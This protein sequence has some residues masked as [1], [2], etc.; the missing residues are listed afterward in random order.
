MA[1]P[2]LTPGERER[3]HLLDGSLSGS[4]NCEEINWISATLY[5][6]VKSRDVFLIIPKIP[7]LSGNLLSRKLVLADATQGAFKIPGEIGKLGAGGN[8][9]LGITRSLIINPTAHITNI[10]H[11]KTLLQFN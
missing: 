11:N 9:V 3:S 7:S 4:I 6:T 8:A 5:L 1:H 10:L 2:V